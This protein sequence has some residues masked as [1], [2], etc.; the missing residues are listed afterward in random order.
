M[1][2]VFKPSFSCQTDTPIMT[3]RKE[4]V[5]QNVSFFRQPLVRATFAESYEGLA[6]WKV[7]NWTKPTYERTTVVVVALG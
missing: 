7:K 4:I 1:N 6:C 3:L 5:S 2:E